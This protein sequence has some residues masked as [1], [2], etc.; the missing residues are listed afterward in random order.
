MDLPV[1][2]QEAEVGQSH[3]ELKPPPVWKRIGHPSKHEESNREGH[4]VENPHRPP[5]SQPD[6]FCNCGENPKGQHQSVRQEAGDPT[7]GQLECQP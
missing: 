6:K 5:V 1:I 4:L 3:G 7:I 2:Q